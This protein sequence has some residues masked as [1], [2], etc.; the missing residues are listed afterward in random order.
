MSIY[1]SVRYDSY[2]TDVCIIRLCMIRT[3]NT[4]HFIL[5]WIRIMYRMILTTMSTSTF[6]QKKMSTSIF[7]C[8]CF[9]F[10]KYSI[11]TTMKKEKFG[12]WFFLLRRGLSNPLINKALGRGLYPSL[13][14]RGNLNFL[15]FL[16]HHYLAYIWQICYSRE[17]YWSS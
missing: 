8:F 1:R 17:L 14:L 13:S 5:N 9:L 11:V 7:F 15:T 6:P 16:P 4:I 10:F 2:D 3:Y 12:S